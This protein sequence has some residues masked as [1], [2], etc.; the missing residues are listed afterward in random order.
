VNRLR[1]ARKVN[2]ALAWQFSKENYHEGAP[3]FIRDLKQISLWSQYG[4]RVI[5]GEIDFR[6]KR[7]LIYEDDFLVRLPSGKPKAF[8][9]SDFCQK[10]V[11]VE[12]VIE[13]V[14]I[15]FIK[16]LFRSKNVRRKKK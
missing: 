4:G 2:L 9:A 7:H 16:R 15:P 8:S 12:E 1:Y 3:Q 10:Y 11:K 6:D 13:E 5:G 14:K